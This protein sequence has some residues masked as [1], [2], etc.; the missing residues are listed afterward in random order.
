MSDKTDRHLQRSS[1]VDGLCCT[2]AIMKVPMSLDSI[3]ETID[4]AM[5]SAGLDTRSAALQSVA[6]T[7]QNALAAAGIAQRSRDPDSTNPAPTQR[8]A[9][10]WTD[11]VLLRPYDID[12]EPANEPSLGTFVT[13]SFS[14]AAGSR[15]YKLYV[16]TCYSGE[17]MPLLLMLHGCKQNPDDFAAGTRMNELA[18]QHGFLVAYPEQP[19]PANGSNCWNWFQA[20]HQG[21]GGGEPSILSGIVGDVAAQVRIDARRVFVAG[22]SA[23]AAMAVILG[24]TYPDVFAAIGVH[25]GLPHGAAHDVA[26]AFA[27][28]HGR[29]PARAAA[30][31][32][33]VAT[34]VFH[35]DH[36][37]TVVVANAGAIVGDAVGADAGL[38]LERE[39]TALAGCTR[40]VYRDA[41]GRAQVEQ[42]LVHGAGHAW[43]G[44]SP[45]GSF[46]R[47][48]GPDASAE[49]VRFFL[50]R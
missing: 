16:P 19:R 32:P 25:S 41:A 22:L 15:N 11:A 2:A 20:A 45:K 49:M 1:R 24:Q 3:S 33:G 43:S 42:W 47:P 28:M 10:E 34:I 44:G 18:Q 39:S 48:S 4:R 40:T 23:G 36:D 5:K 38:A 13:R 12:A 30:A 14:N 31:R 6:A 9:G 37:K 50:A 8:V 17:P 46:T 7:I 26:S 35:G 27:A 29:A 21:R